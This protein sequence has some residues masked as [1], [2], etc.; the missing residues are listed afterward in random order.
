MHA[1]FQNTGFADGVN[2]TAGLPI[3][4][5]SPSHGTAYDIAGKKILLMKIRCVQQYILLWILYATGCNIAK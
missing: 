5:T 1:P 3:V 4:R 2:Y